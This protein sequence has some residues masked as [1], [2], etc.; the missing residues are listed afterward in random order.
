[1]RNAHTML[2]RRLLTGATSA[3]TVWMCIVALTGPLGHADGEPSPA[4]QSPVAARP[5]GA[6]PPA[7]QP[8]T[9]QRV[10]M[11]REAFELLDDGDASAALR[12]L[13]RTVEDAPPET[14]TK[15]EQ[16]T[17][18][19]RGRPL[20]EWMADLRMTAALHPRG[21]QLLDLRF[22]SDYEAPAV[23][24]RLRA[25]LDTVLAREY[26]GK[27]I[28]Q[29]AAERDQYTRLFADAADMVRDAE[30]AAALIRARQRFDPDLRQDRVQRR[31]L[32]QMRDNLGRFVGAVRNMAGFTSL[33]ANPLDPSDPTFQEALR[34][35]A[36]RAAQAAEK[37]PDSAPA[38]QPGAS[39]MQPD[40]GK[41]P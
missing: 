33:T 1:M 39:G 24:R 20:M 22:V 40:D 25:L 23:A 19:L 41:Q 35:E 38:S 14:L 18:L 34:L 16:F 7:S 32:N 15:L 30:F 36:E 17:L 29:W 4:A 28:R 5:D 8:P 11:L 26:R 12:A 10:Q 37:S 31:E 2:N 6:G 27:T 9:P 13:Q 3:A 21:D